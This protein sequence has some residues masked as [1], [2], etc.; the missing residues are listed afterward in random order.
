MFVNKRTVKTCV[1]I[2]LNMFCQCKIKNKTHS[3]QQTKNNKCNSHEIHRTFFGTIQ[4][5]NQQIAIVLC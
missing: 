5:K 4:Q 1:V 3:K 2:V